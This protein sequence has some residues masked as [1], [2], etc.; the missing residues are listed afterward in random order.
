MKSSEL[1]FVIGPSGE[2]RAIYDDDMA[3]LL[4]E[5]RHV[6]IERASHVEPTPSGK[7]IADMSPVIAEYKLDVD[8]PILGPFHLRREALEAEVEWIKEKIMNQNH[9]ERKTDD[10]DLWST[11]DTE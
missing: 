6:S 7:W 2:T 4:K 1:L 3:D 10:D 11:T 9:S 8:N 5:A